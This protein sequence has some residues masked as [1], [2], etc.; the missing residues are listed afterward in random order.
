M[1]ECLFIAH[2]ELTELAVQAACMQEL[3][4]DA[5]LGG[6]GISSSS[7]QTAPHTQGRHSLLHS[8]LK[9]TYCI[10]QTHTFHQNKPSLAF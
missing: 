9:K 3:C 5:T 8:H 1:A 7:S 10:P 6:E 2:A 4:S